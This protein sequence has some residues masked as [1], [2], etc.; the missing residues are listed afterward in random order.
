MVRGPSRSGC[1][2]HQT[3]KPWG[4]VAPAASVSQ[5]GSIARCSTPDQ[6]FSMLRRQGPDGL[7]VLIV[8]YA[9][10]LTGMAVRFG[11]PLRQE[12]EVP[13][14]LV[15]ALRAGRLPPSRVDKRPGSSW[16]RLP[17]RIFH[18]A[19]AASDSSSLGKAGPPGVG[20]GP[21]RAVRGGPA[22]DHRTG[23]ACTMAWDC[24]ARLAWLALWS[25]VR[26]PCGRVP[27]PWTA[28]PSERP[29]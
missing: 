28:S 1:T 11:V 2:S 5:P 20:P 10:P 24:L 26:A 23:R 29:Q 21:E 27:P 19:P 18:S 14:P 25:V 8:E 12:P 13:E 16:E 15:A 7:E 22:A 17:V 9:G 4:G 3:S 6:S